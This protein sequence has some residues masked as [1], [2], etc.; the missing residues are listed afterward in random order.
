VSEFLARA[1]ADWAVVHRLIA[2]GQL[3]EA[4]YEGRKF[5]MRKLDTRRK[6]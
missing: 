1:G 5:Y 2:K 6:Q 3:I 4:E